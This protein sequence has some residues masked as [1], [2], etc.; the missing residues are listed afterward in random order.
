[1]FSRSRLFDVLYNRSNCLPLL[2]LVYRNQ[3]GKW[4][5]SFICLMRLDLLFVFAIVCPLALCLFVYYIAVGLYRCVRNNLEL[6]PIIALLIA[7]THLI[8]HLIIIINLIV[9]KINYCFCEW[10]FNS[11]ATFSLFHLS[12]HY[13]FLFTGYI[14]LFRALN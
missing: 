2:I 1:M 10:I 12:G 11:S 8:N 3:S 14:F 7:I 6:Y 13:L 5:V 4:F 9:K